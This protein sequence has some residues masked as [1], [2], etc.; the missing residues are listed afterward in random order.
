MLNM[1]LMMGEDQLNQNLRALSAGTLVT[2]CAAEL[3]TPIST[4]SSP[5]EPKP[6]YHLL[7]EAHLASALKSLTS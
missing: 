1:L 7:Q 5:L 4:F 6:A 3:T 2:P